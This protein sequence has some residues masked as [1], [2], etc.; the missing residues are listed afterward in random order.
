MVW[1]GSSDP[2]SLVTLGGVDGN[3]GW[4]PLGVDPT[5]LV[6]TQ[7]G[8]SYT[9]A[10]ADAGSQVLFSNGSAVTATV[11][12]NSSVAFPIGTTIDIE[13]AGAG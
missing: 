7:S 4:L 5:V 13:Q 6:T 1:G 3:A 12:P 10:L 8:T 11:P 9:F 2:P